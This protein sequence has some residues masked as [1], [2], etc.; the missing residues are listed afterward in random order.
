MP[1]WVDLPLELTGSRAFE[2]DD[3]SAQ[4]CAW[5]M[6]FW[7]FWYEA[8]H[9]FGLTTVY[10]AIALIGLFAVRRLACWA[11][12]RT[13]IGGNFSKK[14]LAGAR[15]LSYRS[16]RL[17]ALGW[18]SPPLGAIVLIVASVVFFAGNAVDL[19]RACHVDV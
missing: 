18:H 17:Q 16:Y 3:L 15:Y 8:D 1:T 11:M 13:N 19:R 12:P 10:F 4:D 5:Y 9:A 6:Q 7:H 2:C 14:A